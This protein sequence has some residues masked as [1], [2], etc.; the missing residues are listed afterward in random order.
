MAFPET[1][2]AS[3][4]RRQNWTGPFCT[5]RTMKHR[6]KVVEYSSGYVLEDRKSSVSHWLGDGVDALTTPCG[7]SMKPGSEHFRRM[8]QRALNENPSETVEAYGFPVH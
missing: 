2:S 4:Q 1:G 7:R 3:S 8:W 5:E 6:F